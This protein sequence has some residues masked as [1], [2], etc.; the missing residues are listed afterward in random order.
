[1]KKLYLA[2]SLTNKLDLKWQLYQ[3]KI[4]DGGNLM[5][6]M[7]M[8]N[9]I[10]DQMQKVDIKIKEEDKALLLLIHMIVWSPRCCMERI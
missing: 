5:E 8:F 7:N 4:V 6:H 1:M 9:G 2:K 10:V 3:L